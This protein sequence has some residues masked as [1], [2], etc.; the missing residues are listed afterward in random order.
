MGSDRKFPTQVKDIL[1]K[2]Q[3]ALNGS[4]YKSDEKDFSEQA[5]KILLRFPLTGVMS[6]S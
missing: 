6:L 2:V 3:L 5:K 4:F 1:E